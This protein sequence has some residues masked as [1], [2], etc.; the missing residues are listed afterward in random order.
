[1]R[2]YLRPALVA[3]A[4]AVP[5]SGQIAA[6]RRARAPEEL[7]GLLGR[8]ASHLALYAAALALWLMLA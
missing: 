2:T 1:M 6:L 5:V 7:N 4:L 3:A 8:V